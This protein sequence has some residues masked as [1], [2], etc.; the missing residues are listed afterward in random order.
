VDVA[1]AHT[2]TASGAACVL[3]A[4]CD[5]LCAVLTER[6]KLPPVCEKKATPK[7]LQQ[8]LQQLRGGSRTCILPLPSEH[9]EAGSST[10][11]G[12]THGCTHLGGK[13]AS[14]VAVSTLQAIPQPQQPHRLISKCACALQHSQTMCGVRKAHWHSFMHRNHTGGWGTGQRHGSERP[15]SAGAPV[16]SPAA[17]SAQARTT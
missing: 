5:V 4:M 17:A 8:R 6:R 15:A 11:G 10:H 1:S 7:V 12:Y 13:A 9:S 16:A 14:A 3:C 2:V